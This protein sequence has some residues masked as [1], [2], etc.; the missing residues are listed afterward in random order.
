MDMRTETGHS[1]MS[2]LAA[3]QS[4]VSW[5]LSKDLVKHALVDSFRRMTPRYQARNPVM[6]VVYV[7]SILTT[8]LWLQALS[9][10]GEA[11]A[12]FILAV[13][14][15]LWVTLLFANFA[16]AIPQGPSKAQAANLKNARK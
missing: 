10:N 16:E 2:T 12:G 8:I 3:R 1:H 4:G 14:A 13:T 6:F 9:G 15:W 7:G 11:P 5:F